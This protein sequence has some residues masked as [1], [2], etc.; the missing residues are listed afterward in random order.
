MCGL[1]NESLLLSMRLCEDGFLL[2]KSSC[3]SEIVQILPSFLEDWSLGCECQVLEDELQEVKV[4]LAEARAVAE[5]ASST[6]DKFRKERDFHRMHHKRV[7]Q[8][9]NHL[10]TDIKRLKKHYSQYEPTIKELKNKYERA[11]KEKM[12]LR[13]DWEKLQ[14][15]VS[16]PAG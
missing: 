14:A 12:L 9:K 13:L 11:M 6:W 1:M 3:T 4:E 5:K 10:I 2:V 15:K 16:V 8:E 7:A